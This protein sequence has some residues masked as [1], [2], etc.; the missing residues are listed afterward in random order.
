MR[1]IQ[2]STLIFLLALHSG[3]S[4]LAPGRAF[5]A[6]GGDDGGF[7]NPNVDFPVVVGDS[8]DYWPSEQRR[9]G[10]AN[11]SPYELVLEQELRTLE[12]RQDAETDVLY[13]RYRNHF[14]TVSERIFF[15]KLDPEERE[16]YLISR[17]FIKVEPT[18]QSGAVARRPAQAGQTKSEGPQAVT[19]G[20][21][22]E[23]VMHYLGRPVRV[24]IAGSP[25]EQNERWLYKTQGASKYIYFEGGAVDGW[26]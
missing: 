14:S 22:K 12:S 21:T 1:S 26:E 5:I 10:R 6:E 18:P 17:G 24:E 11:L 16:D 23:E 19:M 25:S 4:G 20:M 15:L 9:E 7:F 13:Q 3:C 2:L 8:G